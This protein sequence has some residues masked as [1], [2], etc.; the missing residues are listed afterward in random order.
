MT[1]FFGPNALVT[2]RLLLILLVWQILFDNESLFHNENI[3]AIRPY[4]SEIHNG[5][6]N[7]TNPLNLIHSDNIAHNLRD[8]EDM[9]ADDKMDEIMDNLHQV[10]M[11]DKLVE[12]LDIMKGAI[13]HHVHP[14]GGKE[15][16]GD[17][18]GY[19]NKLKDYDLNKILSEYVRIS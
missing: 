16:A 7:Q 2:N 10:P 14:C 15:Q 3:H 17:T 6:C 8:Q 18:P 12:I 5:I 19:I 4:H 11:G 13:L 9:I 1:Y